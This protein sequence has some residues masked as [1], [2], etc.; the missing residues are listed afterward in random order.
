VIGSIP[1]HFAHCLL[2]C[3][4]HSLT[5]SDQVAFREAACRQKIN[6]TAQSSPP[7]HTPS[8]TVSSLSIASQLTTASAILWDSRYT[9][10]PPPT[11][12][13]PTHVGTLSLEGRSDSTISVRSLGGG[14]RI[15]PMD[16][17]HPS[18]FQQL[19]K[20]GE[21]TYATVSNSHNSVKAKPR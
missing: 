12:L 3:L 18:S 16:K 10:R 6:I 4:S 7:R 19:E 5:R 17:R 9:S 14:Q 8:R 15:P 13:H 21:G 1:S 2:D 11:R 20:L